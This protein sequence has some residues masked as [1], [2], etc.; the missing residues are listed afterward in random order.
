MVAKK[1]GKRRS[2]AV[3]ENVKLLSFSLC[4]VGKK[5]TLTVGVK[6]K[7]RK[8]ALYPKKAFS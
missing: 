5:N 4:F 8:K 3:S 2:W 6:S 1:A 7:S